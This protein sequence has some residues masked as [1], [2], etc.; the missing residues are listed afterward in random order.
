MIRALKSHGKSL[1]FICDMPILNNKD[2]SEKFTLRMEEKLKKMFKHP[3][4]GFNS[5][6]YLMKNLWTKILLNSHSLVK[7][8]PQD[9]G[10]YFFTSCKVLPSVG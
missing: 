3:P 8:I 6:K 2:I 7:G 9:I 10:V 1:S 4:N 5:K